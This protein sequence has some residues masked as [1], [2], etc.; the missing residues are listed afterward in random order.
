MKS[1][2]IQFSTSQIHPQPQRLAKAKRS[3]ST[4]RLPSDISNFKIDGTRVPEAG[5]VVLATVKRLGQHRR[6]ELIDGRRARMFV[7]DDIV[8]VFGNRYAPD[9]FEAIVPDDMGPCHLAAAGG[10]AGQMIYKHDAMKKPTEIEPVGVLTRNDGKA[11]NLRDYAFEPATL[12]RPLPPVIAVA[13]GAM[14]TGKTTTAASLVH[15][16]TLAG[17]R[18]NAGKV[19]G[20][21]SGCDSWHII[22]AGACKM[23][24]FLDAGY[25]STYLLS[26]SQ[27][28]SI[29]ENLVGHLSLEKPDFII[30]EVAD[31]LL[32]KETASLISSKVFRETVAG[33]VFTAVDAMGAVHGVEMLRR[34]TVPVLAISGVLSRS[35]LAVRESLDLADIPV[36]S[37]QALLDPGIKHHLATWLGNGISAA[38]ARGNG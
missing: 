31:G 18:V 25:P 21:G 16:L 6:I 22:D 37:R 26:P 29:F 7:R 2:V 33:V 23:M 27:V 30:L 8:V 28:E 12:S 11:V 36:L 38:V 17:F 32:Q 24:D 20:T 13:G 34:W 10:I 14:N 1:N 5:D 4:R 9:Q 3:Y 19:T 35:P 15:G